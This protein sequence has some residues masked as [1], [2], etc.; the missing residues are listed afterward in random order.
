M[1]QTTRCKDKATLEHDA[2]TS[3]DQNMQAFLYDIYEKIPQ[4]SMFMYAIFVDNYAID[5]ERLLLR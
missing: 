1:L 5:L 3:R 2:K 4:A